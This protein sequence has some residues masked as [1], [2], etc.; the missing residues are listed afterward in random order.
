MLKPT[1]HDYILSKNHI[2]ALINSAV[3]P[4]DC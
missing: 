4:V 2:G 1:E 3:E